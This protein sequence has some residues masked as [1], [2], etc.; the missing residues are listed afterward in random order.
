MSEEFQP[1]KP[2]HR[3]RVMTKDGKRKGTIGAAWQRSDGS[4]LLRLD[5]CVVV[6]WDDDVTISLFPAEEK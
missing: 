6:R 5:P 4:F 1:G 3:L 2:T